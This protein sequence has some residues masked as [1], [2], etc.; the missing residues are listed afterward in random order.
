VAQQ[1]IR[2]GSGN[3]CEGDKYGARQI[4]KGKQ[5][6]QPAFEKFFAAFAPPLGL[7]FAQCLSNDHAAQDQKNVD[8]DSSL[9][10]QGHEPLTSHQVLLQAGNGNEMKKHHPQ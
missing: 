8:T 9:A 6:R 3:H 2:C 5:P 7:G 10:G 1:V 4:M